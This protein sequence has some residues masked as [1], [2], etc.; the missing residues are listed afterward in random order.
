M[1]QLALLAP[2]RGD[3][4]PNPPRTPGVGVWGMANTLSLRSEGAAPP[5]RLLNPL[6]ELSLLVLNPRPVEQSGLMRVREGLWSKT[7]AL[8]PPNPASEAGAASSP[9]VPG[10]K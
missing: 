8:W 1:K 2:G 4:A 3:G 6:L 7:E 5:K 10:S 9:K